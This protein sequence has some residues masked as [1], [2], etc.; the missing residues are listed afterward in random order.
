M[1]FRVEPA[2]LGGWRVMLEGVDTPVSVHDTE[3]EAQARADAY[4]RGAEAAASPTRETGVPRGD[5]VELPDGGT[6][7]VRPIRPED[8][9]LLLD[10]FAHAFGPESRYRRF[11]TPKNELSPSELA[12]FTELD[13][14]RHEAIGALD[15]DTGAGVG[16]ARFVRDGP[17]ADAAEVAVAVVDAWQG[18][19]L[20][21]I[22]LDRLADRAREV[23]VT[24]FT[25]S[26]LASN[27]AML[28]LFGRL[29]HME[30]GHD[31]GTTA[32]I[33]VRLDCSREVLRPA[34]RAAAAGDVSA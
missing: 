13:H 7:I 5:R 10:S 28:A 6:V 24:T 14:D 1:R 29:G 3:E 23:G 4:A 33:D 16:V 25:A 21:G 27:R 30:V 15:P 32:H 17:G 31:T 9:P 22:L 34:L 19:G 18:R 11:F 8:A 2:A 26:L 20:G 12:Y